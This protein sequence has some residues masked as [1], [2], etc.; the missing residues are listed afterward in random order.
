MYMTTGKCM[1]INNFNLTAATPLTIY[2]VDVAHPGIGEKVQEIT[3]DNGAIKS[4]VY[5]NFGA[6]Q[7][8]EIATGKT[9]GLYDIEIVWGGTGVIAV[10]VGLDTANHSAYSL[11][12]AAPMFYKNVTIS[13]VAGSKF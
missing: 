2:D 9:A 4:T 12:N 8:I 1:S 13:N 3:F 10:K 7:E 6:V 11:P 5:N